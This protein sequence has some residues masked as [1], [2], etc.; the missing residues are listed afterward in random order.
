MTRSQRDVQATAI[1]DAAQ[2][3]SAGDMDGTGA[4]ALVAGEATKLNAHLNA[5]RVDTADLVSKL[6]SVI[7]ALEN[8]GIL[9]K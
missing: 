5:I 4:D 3:Q 1:A 9:G 7:A 2:T 8:R 6:N